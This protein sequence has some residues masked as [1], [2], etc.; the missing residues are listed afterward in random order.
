M[1][2]SFFGKQNYNNQ[3]I[4]IGA[5]EPKTGKIKLQAQLL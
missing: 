5:I 2:E 4:V 3:R 1:D